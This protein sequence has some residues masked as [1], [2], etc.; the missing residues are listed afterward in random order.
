M[1]YHVSVL[2]FSIL[3]FNQSAATFGEETAT[4]STN[5]PLTEKSMWDMM[6]DP[7]D[8]K[9]DT[10]AWLATAKGFFPVPIIITEPAVGYGGGLALLFFHDS[11]A[12]RAEQVKEQ[13]PDGTPK[14]LAPPSISGV[15]GIA[16]E[17][18]TW[19]A[20]GFH[21][22]VWKD[23]TIRYLG[24][25][26]Y[27]S[28]NYDFYPTAGPIE[29]IPINIEGAF[30]LQQMTFRLGESHFFAGTNYK[31]LSSTAKPDQG[32][33]LPP[34]IEDGVEIQSGGASGILEFDSR[35]N[36]FTPNRGLNTKGEWTHYDTWLGS[37]NQFD[38]LTWN[39]RGW[40]P[41]GES[42]VLGLR[43]DGDFTGGDIPFYMLPFVN[44]RGIPAMRYQG[45]HVITTEAELRWDV[46]QRWSLIGFA[47][48]GWTAN[49]DVSDFSNSDT[50]PAGGFGFRYLVA[51]VFNMR[52]GLDFGF[53]EVDQAVY[54]TT[55]SAWH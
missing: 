52:A 11:I 45:D 21:M 16:T 30:L 15:F 10:S 25:L 29:Q 32:T 51:K 27:M 46:T 1:K 44:I 14:H 55:G 4:S 39:N 3:L 24:A 34:P 35:D 18:G 50:Y 7:E 41:L 23:D 26:G 33:A 49:G 20:G 43:L 8:G 31:L 37:D 12:N 36:I 5:S 19:G 17:N 40:H 6:I 2:L 48:A 54:I 28:V 53:S 9:F 22:G 38:I 42:F 47:G 13:N